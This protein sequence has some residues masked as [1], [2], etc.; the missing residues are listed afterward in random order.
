M[1][2]LL[3]LC[4]YDIVFKYK[5]YRHYLL[6]LI[7]KFNCNGIFVLGILSFFSG[8]RGTGPDDWLSQS[9]VPSEIK[10]IPQPRQIKTTQ[11]PCLIDH[12]FLILLESNHNEYDRLSAE[13][14][15]E[16]LKNIWNID[17]PVLVNDSLIPKNK[18]IILLGIPQ[19]DRLIR[20]RTRRIGLMPNESLGEEGYLLSVTPEAVF[21]LANHSRGLFYG[22]QSIRQLMNQRFDSVL[23][24][25]VTITDWPDFKYRGL[26]LDISRSPLPR[27]EYLKKIIQTLAFYKINM[28]T[29]YTENVFHFKK[30][31][32]ITS[33]PDVLTPE[34]VKELVAY[35]KKYQIE[36]VGNFQSFSPLDSILKLPQYQ[37]L[38]DNQQNPLVLSP[39]KKESYEFLSEIYRELIPLYESKFFHINC[40]EPRDA[41]GRNPYDWN[42]PENSSRDLFLKGG[43]D[44]IYNR[45]F[46]NLMDVLEPYHEK[47]MFWADA[48]LKHQRIIEKLPRGAI[49]MN[50]QFSPETSDS[51]QKY[52]YRSFILPL[53][54]AHLEQFVCPGLW[55]ERQIFPVIPK[56]TANIKYFLQEGWQEKVMGAMLCSSWPRPGGDGE[57]FT[58]L[59]WYPITWFAECAW[60]PERSNESVFNRKFTYSFYG[61][62]GDEGP[63]LIN[64]LAQ[65]HTLLNFPD[66]TNN[67]LWSDPFTSRFSLTVAD[68]PDRIKT[69]KQI[70]QD[71]A[72]RS[73]IL[74]QKA[75]RHQETL[76]YLFLAARRWEHLADKF[77]QTESLAQLYRT[78]YSE[79]RYDR[80]A[81]IINLEK[82]NK[83]MEELSRNA[84]ALQTIYLNLWQPVYRQHLLKENLNKFTG[85]NNLYIAKQTQLKN[86]LADFT[87]NETL[88]EPFALNL[89]TKTFPQRLITPSLVSS[90]PEVTKIFRWWDRDW[91]YRVKLK[92]EN[93]EERTDY[94][95]E[96]H[97]NFSELLEELKKL[98]PETPISSGPVPISIS[99]G[100]DEEFDLNSTRVIEYSA[101]GSPLT[102]IPFQSD[103][104]PDFNPKYNADV[105]LFW[106]IN[107]TL[108][109]DSTRSF[110]VYFDTKP[111]KKKSPKR[112]PDYKIKGLSAKSARKG[113]A[114]V[115]NKFMKVLV[116]RRGGRITR[117]EI[118]KMSDTDIINYDVKKTRAFLETPAS[119]FPTT[120]VPT[121][122]V[123]HRQTSTERRDGTGGSD[124]QNAMFDLTCEANGPLMTRYHAST[125]DGFSKR[126]TFYHDL[127]LCE[128]TMNVA[129]YRIHN[130][131]TEPKLIEPVKYLFP[132]YLT[133]NILS[134]RNQV[135]MNPDSHWSLR[136]TP[137][138]L[139]LACLTPDNKT[140]HYVRLDNVK[141]ESGGFTGDIGV[142]DK[143]TPVAHFIIFADVISNPADIFYLMNR[144]KTT[145]TT[146]NQ[147]TI[148]RERV[149]MKPE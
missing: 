5:V 149:E 4:R 32:Q 128:V 90:T 81:V 9:S 29:L 67:L 34:E 10:I 106:R 123:V 117:W 53:K 129:T 42:N 60:L 51:S 107:G 108:T 135:I 35:A 93:Y 28:L 105:N 24:P 138:G 59:A 139:T 88:P 65:P 68:F 13:L 20:E 133:G 71:S 18:K 14:I 50:W 41:S 45:H 113:N 40:A 15:R 26:Q 146:V 44:D 70:A 57:N 48:S 103:P 78:T 125:P 16:D 56:T 122:G 39:V 104:R 80:E 12:N 131:N 120:L 142:E 25:G 100:P 62:D 112:K 17:V 121:E 95:T 77:Q 79:Q 136:T 1:K 27:M 54:N 97:L 37:H 110:C 36:L 119:P 140:T 72:A 98:R 74:K 124:N 102:E 11:L 55:S 76:D 130:Y 87:L 58:D 94:P 96:V 89:E 143:S 52:Q 69:I 83:I 63:E 73:V 115:E 23:V 144:L 8:C 127:P 92:I 132:N 19:R 38:A 46:H 2:N 134:E 137:G 33:T 114:W 145:F 31:P 66:S 49:A 30:H 64:Q 118:K 109:K 7:K 3:G 91:R 101:D 141:N 75:R 116:D 22:A 126:L 82:S 99:S 86:I 47:I 21:I 84:A 43:F 148:Q 111:V 6:T 85:L 61:V 147:P